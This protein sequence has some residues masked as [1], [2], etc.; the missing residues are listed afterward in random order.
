MINADE[1]RSSHIVRAD[2]Y[3]V[4]HQFRVTHCNAPA[5]KTIHLRGKT[6]VLLIV[7]DVAGLID[8]S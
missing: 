7:L 1:Q 3:S 5:V 6:G 4:L 8:A 2:H